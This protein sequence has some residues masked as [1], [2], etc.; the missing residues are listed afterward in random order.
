MMITKNITFKLFVLITTLVASA[1]A[2]TGK[3]ESRMNEKKGMTKEMLIDEMGIPD[4][5]YKSENFE[6]IEYNQ[7]GEIRLPKNSTSYVGLNQIQT[8]T[9][10]NSFTSSCKLEFKIINGVVANYR[11]NGSLCKSN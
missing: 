2:T 4:R 3:F 5:I 9:Y 11:Y 6:I 8:T 10:D 7:S 1:C